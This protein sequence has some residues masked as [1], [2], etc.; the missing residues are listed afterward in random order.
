MYEIMKNVEIKYYCGQ[1]YE[2][3]AIQFN[4][5]FVWEEISN[6]IDMKVLVHFT[7]SLKLL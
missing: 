5:K 4:K 7:I 6:R 3:Q 2:Y 1:G